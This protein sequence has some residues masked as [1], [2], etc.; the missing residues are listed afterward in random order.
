MNIHVT[1]TS[2]I[3]KEEVWFLYNSLVD[4]GFYRLVTPEQEVVKG[5]GNTPFAIEQTKQQLE[6]ATKAEIEEYNKLA[7]KYNNMSKENMRINAEEVKRFSFLY[8]KMTL[9]QREKAEPFPNVEGFPSAPP[10]PDAPIELDS[11][12]N[13]DRWVKNFDASYQNGKKNSSS[14]SIIFTIND[15]ESFSI[16]T[17]PSTMENYKTTLKS[18]FKKFENIKSDEEIQVYIKSEELVKWSFI[19]EVGKELKKYN[20]ET[21]NITSGILYDGNEINL[22]PPT[23]PSPPA[24]NFEKDTRLPPLPAP[25]PPAPLNDPIEYIKALHKSGAVFYIGPHQYNYE[26]VLELAKKT[27]D[28]RIDISQY[29]KVSLLGC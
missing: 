13:K 1:S 14:K 23:P 16:N 15:D 26:E 18:L 20:I 19:Q 5:K 11:N 28:L 10:A 6:K 12:L 24:P 4:Y 25:A 8:H 21:I 9:E 3:S 27:T 29:P 2:E 22:N 17:I 7:K